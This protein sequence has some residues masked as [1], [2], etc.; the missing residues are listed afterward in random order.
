VCLVCHKSLL[1]QSGV[2]ELFQFI[3]ISFHYYPPSFLQVLHYTKSV[4][5]AIRHGAVIV[6]AGSVAENRCEGESATSPMHAGGQCCRHAVA[7]L[8]ARSKHMHY[9]KAAWTGGGG[10]TGGNRRLGAETLGAGGER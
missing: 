8:S 6:M 3:I 7:M 4:A 9:G 10:A 2:L 5:F 1:S